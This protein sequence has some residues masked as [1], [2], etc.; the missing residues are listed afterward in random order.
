VA[1][2]TNIF[3]TPLASDRVAV[4]HI[5]SDLSAERWMFYYY[6]RVHALTLDTYQKLSRATK[7]HGWKVEAAYGRLASSRDYH[8]MENPPL[9]EDVKYEAARRFHQTLRVGMW[10]D[11][12][13]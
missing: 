3:D 6:S 5:H 1:R 11:Y 7:R 12:V 10:K 2:S 8:N 13:R 4:N 9:P